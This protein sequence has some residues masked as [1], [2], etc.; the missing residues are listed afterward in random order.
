MS[1]PATKYIVDN[2]TITENY[3]ALLLP[4]FCDEIDDGLGFCRFE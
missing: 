3:A 1:V 4:I 2:Q